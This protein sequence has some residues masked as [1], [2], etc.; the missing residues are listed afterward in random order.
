MKHMK[1]LEWQAVEYINGNPDMP[2]EMAGFMDIDSRTT[3]KGGLQS[4][5][6]ELYPRQIHWNS[7][8]TRIN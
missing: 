1:A 3:N 6:L 8:A 2:R 5:P 7:I 4:N